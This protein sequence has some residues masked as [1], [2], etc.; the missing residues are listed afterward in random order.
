MKKTIFLLWLIL[1]AFAAQSQTIDTS[2][3]SMTACKIKPFKAQFNDTLNVTHLGMRIIG[4]DMK[5]TATLY[6]V[7]F[8]SNG[9][10][11]AEG[12]EVIGGEDY[13]N[14]DGSNL[15]P[16][17]FVAKKLKIELLK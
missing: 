1:G 9:V 11:S 15:F 13:K 3:N 16:F 14:W 5:G 10:K 8:Q 2:F 17:K 7:L 6:W 4:D 12:N